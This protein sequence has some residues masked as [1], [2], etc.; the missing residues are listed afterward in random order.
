[1][2]GYLLPEV[3]AQSSLLAR[4]TLVVNEIESIV[5]WQLDH[6]FSEDHSTLWTHCS[7]SGQFPRADTTNF[8]KLGGLKQLECIFSQFQ[9]P[10]PEIKVSAELVP[11]GGS[12]GG[13]SLPLSWL[14]A[15]ATP[16]W[17]SLISG[18]C[19]HFH[20]AFSVSIIFSF[21]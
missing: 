1:M 15:V 8:Y 18:A 21:W 13:T 14:L 19:F 11:S 16:P 12:E 5:V 6:S 10:E 4:Y 20:T 3:T 17:S 2:T 7:P 9:G